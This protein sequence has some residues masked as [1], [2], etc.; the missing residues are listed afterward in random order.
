MSIRP[1]H[2]RFAGAALAAALGIAA[3]TACT[4]SPSS[5]AS[6]SDAA[7]EKAQHAIR[8]LATSGDTATG[9][10]VA[11]LRTQID[12]YTIVERLVSQISEGGLPSGDEGRR[13]QSSWIDPSRASLTD[14]RADLAALSSAVDDGRDAAVPGLAAQ[15]AL[16]GTDGVDA[17]YLEQQGMPACAALF[18]P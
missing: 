8:D 15:A 1:R 5:F 3:I 14:R 2:P 9:A 16:A 4:P 6:D 12:R 10:P 18:A 11:A 17:G 7:C 13:L